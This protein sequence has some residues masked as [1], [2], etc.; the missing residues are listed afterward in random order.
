MDD[1]PELSESFESFFSWSFLR[2]RVFLLTPVNE[3]D[4]SASSSLAFERVTVADFSGVAECRVVATGKV[5]DDASDGVSVM[6]EQG[7][8]EKLVVGTWK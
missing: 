7:W 8:I 3:V 4:R 5:V 1:L 2:A 6:N